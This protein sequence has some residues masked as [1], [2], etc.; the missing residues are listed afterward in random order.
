MK[1]PFG[2][3]SW[4]LSMKIKYFLN[5]VY[6]FSELPI[7][8]IQM[9]GLIGVLFSFFS[10]FFV[11]LGKV[12]GQINVPGYTATVIFIIFFGSLNILALSII[13]GYIYRTYENTK[14]RPKY[15]VINSCSFNKGS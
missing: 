3:S 2:K 7:K 12:F 4:N 1:R 10:G 13:A 5:S 8:I 9:I 11:L 6:A 14:A 15:V